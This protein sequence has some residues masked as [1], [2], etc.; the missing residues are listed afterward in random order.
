MLEVISFHGIGSSKDPLFVNKNRF[1]EV[2]LWYHKRNYVQVKYNNIKKDS[3]SFKSKS[4]LFTFDDAYESVMEA[5]PILEKYGYTGLLF[6]TTAHIG[7]NNSYKISDLSETSKLLSHKQINFLI[8]NGWKVASH[9]HSHKILGSLQKIKDD[10][11]SCDHSLNNYTRGFLDH[12]C[13]PKNKVLF[14]FIKVYQD[15]YS[16]LYGTYNNFKFFPYVLNRYEVLDSK[17]QTFLRYTYYKLRCFY[18]L[19]LYKISL[20]LKTRPFHK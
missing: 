3:L 13:F 18:H 15:Q 14:D 16:I 12:H 1:E 20:S 2:I 19:L 9:S 17:K 10:I 11:R 8:D 7:K 6:I 5:Y 4:V